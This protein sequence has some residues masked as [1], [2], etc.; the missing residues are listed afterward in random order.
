MKTYLKALVVGA[1]LPA[2]LVP[3]VLYLF[4]GFGKEEVL[5]KPVLHVIPL[6]W[7]LWNVLFV[8]L[9]RHILIPRL[10]YWVAG[11]VLG[12][13]VAIWGV[14]WLQL[15]SM[16]GLSGLFGLLPLVGVPVVYALVWRWVVKPLN[17]AMVLNDGALR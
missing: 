11:G 3:L 1:A 2:L 15:P 13:L 9:F 16:L 6:I 17:E 5:T 8:A 7:G 4:V 10:S 12:L 14:F